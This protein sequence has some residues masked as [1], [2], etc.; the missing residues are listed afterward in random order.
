MRNIVRI[1]GVGLA[2]MT[3]ILLVS[4]VAWAQAEETPIA[5]RWSSCGELEE[6]ESSGWTRTGSNT[7]AM[8]CI[9]AG[10]LDLSRA[11]KRVGPAGNEIR[12]SGSRNA[13]TTPSRV[14]S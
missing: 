5:G 2:A 12:E 1:I 13:G 11:S 4:G 7:G 9:A 10:T 3:G 6:P 8:R 14:R